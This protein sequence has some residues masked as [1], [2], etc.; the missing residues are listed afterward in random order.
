[1]P[2]EFQSALSVL[3]RVA[4]GLAASGEY[5]R[6]WCSGAVEGPHFGQEAGLEPGVEEDALGVDGDESIDR[7]VALDAFDHCPDGVEKL[8]VGASSPSR[9]A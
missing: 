3:A 4:D 6:F 5:V 2:V 9:T 8:V 7:L 1:M